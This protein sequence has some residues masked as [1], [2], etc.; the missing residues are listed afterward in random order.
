LHTELREF[1][2]QV[3][4][5]WHRHGLQRNVADW[6]SIWRLTRISDFPACASFPWLPRTGQRRIAQWSTTSPLR[7][8]VL[9]ASPEAAAALWVRCAR[10]SEASRYCRPCVWTGSDGDHWGL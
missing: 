1:S 10:S 9:R 6:N 2:E 8:T 3:E 7:H 5:L 4:R